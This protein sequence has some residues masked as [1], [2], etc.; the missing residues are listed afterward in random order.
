MALYEEFM[1]PCTIMVRTRTPDGA[2]GWSTAWDDGET[3]DAAIVRNS[4]ASDRIAEK[5]EATGDYTVTVGRDVALAFHQAFK[6]V[7]DGKTFRVVGFKDPTPDM[8]T[9]QFNQYRADEWELA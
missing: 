7:S 9:F 2:G 3:F 5:L 4:G 6:R 8:A 1:T